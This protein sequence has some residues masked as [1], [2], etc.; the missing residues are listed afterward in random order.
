MEAG[1]YSREGGGFRCGLCFRRCLLGEGQRGFCGARSADG[2]GFASSLLGRFCS[3][4][5]DPIEKKPIHHW[6]PGTSILS[7]GSLGCTM[8]CPFCQNH[9]ISRPEGP[10]PLVSM[11]PELLV[12]RLRELH[13]KAVAYTYNEPTLQAEYILAAAPMLEKAGVKTVLVTNGMMSREA[14]ADLASVTAAANIDVKTFN[15]DIYAAMGGSLERVKENV[16]LMLEAGVHVE[17]TT[18]VVP[19]LSDDLHEFACL[20]DWAAG[21]SPALPLHISRYFPAHRYNEPATDL[22]LLK[23]FETLALARLQHVHLGNVR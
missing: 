7:L 10:S 12:A 8:N 5:V 18:L 17:L 20:V 4:A 1:Y 2:D 15:P 9:A 6:R 19:G 23:S 13:L 21:L 14:A 11:S 3:I 16:A 22:D